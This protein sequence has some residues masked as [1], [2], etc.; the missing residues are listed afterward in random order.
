MTAKNNMMVYGNLVVGGE[1]RPKS[2]RNSIIGDPEDVSTAPEAAENI[3][4]DGSDDILE[5]LLIGDNLAIY[6]GRTVTLA[7]FIGG[8]E[9]W[10]FRVTIAGIGPLSGRGIMDFG[11]SHEFLGPDSQ[12]EYDGLTIT[13]ISGHVWRDVIKRRAPN[14]L[15]LLQA[16]ID[17][18]NGEVIWIIPLAT[19]AGDDTTG[20]PETAF[21]QHYLEDPQVAERGQLSSGETPYTQRNMP[22]TASGFFERT[23]TITFDQITNTFAENN[24]RWNDSF[25]QA[26]FPWNLFGD[27]NGNIF[28]LGEV[29]SH[30]GASISSFF[31]IGR[32][33]SADGRHK[34]ILKRLYP[35]FEQLIGTITITVFAA[36]SYDGVATEI[37]TTNFDMQ[38]LEDETFTSIFKQARYYEIEFA[39]SGTGKPFSFSGMIVENVLAGKR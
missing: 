3:V 12:Y 26:A 30:D 14:R 27:N 38:L 1:T 15:D 25:F 35:F 21:V 17:E 39:L 16:H 4:D 13:E 2:I 31:R 8:A 6:S 34:T 5:M 32:F 29:D 28:I 22:M 7:Q 24:Q 11:D 10:A 18:S 19:D 36:D 33:I 37:Y 23:D 20:P 9:V